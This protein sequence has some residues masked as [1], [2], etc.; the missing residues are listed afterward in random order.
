MELSVSRR[1]IVLYYPTDDWVDA[2]EILIWTYILL[3]LEQ[4]LV[5]RVAHSV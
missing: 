4:Q 3:W 1:K 2:T 5:G